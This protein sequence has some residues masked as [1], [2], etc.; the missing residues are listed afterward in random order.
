MNERP[1]SP[2]EMDN[3][4]LVTAIK[5][6][7]A[8]LDSLEREAAHRDIPPLEAQAM[9]ISSWEH[10]KARILENLARLAAQAPHADAKAHYHLLAAQLEI[11]ELAN[12]S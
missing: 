2:K 12:R 1:K 7:R 10:Y 8:R 9:T 11:L 3:R 4:H 5:Y 6:T